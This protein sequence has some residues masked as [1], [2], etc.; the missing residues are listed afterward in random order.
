MRQ[1]S[2]VEVS[3][4]HSHNIRSSMDDV[5]LRQL[6]ES[7][8][9]GQKFPIFYKAN[10]D[11][12]DGHRRVAAAKLAGITHLDGILV[13]DGEDITELQTIAAFHSESLSDFD[14]AN[15]AQAVRVAKGFNNKQLADHLKIDPAQVTKY[16]S[17]FD[18]I[19]EALEAAR[20][21]RI[22]VTVWYI[23]S[24][25]PDQAATL[26]LKLGGA[27]RDEIEQ[28]AR[29]QRKPAETAVRAAKIK[30]PLVSGATVTI[31]GDGVSMDEALEAVQEAAKQLKTAIAKGITAKNAMGYWADLAAAG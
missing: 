26:A 25:S 29:K 9:D 3:T 30:I 6:A 11:L 31:A 23:V 22:G 7:L 1:I 5:A 14:K 15:A 2:K 12:V 19:P 13:D 17:L 8:K 24:K 18:C 16:L 28:Q 21:G 20:A 4:L 27:T 10:R